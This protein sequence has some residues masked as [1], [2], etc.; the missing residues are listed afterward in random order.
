M[1][2]IAGKVLFA[3]K[4]SGC[5]ALQKYRLTHLEKSANVTM[6]DYD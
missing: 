1:N 3:V 4:L 2:F 5:F 6:L